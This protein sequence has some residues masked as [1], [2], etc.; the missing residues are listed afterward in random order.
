MKCI[1]IKNPWLELL[2]RGQKT[3]EIRNWKPR[4]ELPQRVLLHAGKKVDSEAEILFNIHTMN[5][6]KGAI[7]GSALLW[8][9]K[10]YITKESWI[11]DIKE[12]RNLPEWYLSGLSGL[13]FKDVQRFK[14]PIP[15]K[16][17]LNFFEVPDKIVEKII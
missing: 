10:T 2:L 5:S 6:N 13:V 11:R 17:Q 14:I 8:S 7:L 3:I 1:S 15:W 12:H 4:F 9:I 16:G